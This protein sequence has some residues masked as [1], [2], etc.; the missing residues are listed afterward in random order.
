M[1]DSLSSLPT[2][3]RLEIAQEIVTKIEEGLL[4]LYNVDL[5]EIFSLIEESY[6]DDNDQLHSLLSYLMQDDL[7]FFLK[8]TIT[9]IGDA[10]VSLSEE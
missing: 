5:E 7:T 10:D 6:R 8:N 2:Y 9:K 4:G 3:E 1:Y